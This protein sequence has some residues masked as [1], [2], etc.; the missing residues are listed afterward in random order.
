MDKLYDFLIEAKKQTYANANIEKVQSSR[1]GSK[2]YEYKK[3]TTYT[4]NDIK[5]KIID[6]IKSIYKVNE[7]AEY[8]YNLYKKDYF[9]EYD[10]EIGKCILNL[11]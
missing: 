11:I 2:D 1:N 5:E 3:N 6:G 8:I 4:E 7:A 9:Y 10:K